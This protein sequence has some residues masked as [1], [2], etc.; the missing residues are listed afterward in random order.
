MNKI[1]KNLFY[2]V[3]KIVL[4]IDPEDWVDI[5]P[6]DEYD[7]YVAS[8]VSLIINKRFD[9]EALRKIFPTSDINKVHLMYQLLIL[10]KI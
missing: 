10:I 9:M 5:A 4:Q 3:K 2:K 1:Y 7:D 8:V 6:D